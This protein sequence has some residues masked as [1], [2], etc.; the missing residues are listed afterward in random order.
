MVWGM[1]LAEWVRGWE[2]F[3]FC[4]RWWGGCSRVGLRGYA[5]EVLYARRCMRGA[6]VGSVGEEDEWDE[7]A[8]TFMLRLDSTVWLLENS[9]MRTGAP[10]QCKLGAAKPCCG[11]MLVRLSF[12][13]QHG[14]AGGPLRRS[15]E[16][17]GCR[18]MVGT[19]QYLR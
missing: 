8:F 17:A 12:A 15:L 2:V 18:L 3:S 4:G 9:T 10:P 7:Y 6:A 1:G 16:V 13:G 14:F 19:L 5:A 11:V